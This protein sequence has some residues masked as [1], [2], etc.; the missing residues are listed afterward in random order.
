MKREI[1]FRAF[2]KSE[3]HMYSWEEIENTSDNRL[4][5]VFNGL[6]DV[7]YVF[8]QYTGLKDK[9]GVEIYEG[10]IVL[11]RFYILGADKDNLNG[12]EIYDSKKHGEGYYNIKNTPGCFWEGQKPGVVSFGEITTDG[13]MGDADFLAW[14]YGNNSILE[15]VD[16]L[17]VIGNI[18]QNKDLITNE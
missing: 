5:E 3:E 4:Y 11:G 7:G 8:M 13:E 1:K 12:Y 17:E 14:K 15:D 16:K 2:G 6:V 10:D 9:N 18:Y